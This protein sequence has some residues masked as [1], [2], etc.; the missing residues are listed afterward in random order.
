MVAEQS[1]QASPGADLCDRDK[2]GSPVVS[3]GNRGIALINRLAVVLIG[4]VGLTRNNLRLEG[5][6]KVTTWINESG[7]P[8]LQ[9]TTLIESDLDDLAANRRR[10]RINDGQSLIKS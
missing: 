9:Q 3:Q 6:A 4:Q 2:R 7:F 5:I 10:K 1:Y 8:R